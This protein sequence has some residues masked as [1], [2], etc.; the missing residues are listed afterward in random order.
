M[1]VKASAADLALVEAAHCIIAQR[2]KPGWHGVGAALRTRTGRIFTG[3]HLEAHVGRIAI[4]AEAVALGRA[5]T[6]A[7]D[8]DIDTIVAVFHSGKDASDPIIKVAAPCGMCREMISDY[9]PGA[10]VILP[11]KTGGLVRKPV[12]RLLPDKYVRP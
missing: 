1:T 11:R 8:T 6:E 5:A 4:C 9:S 7:G 12:F 2:Y 10:M 3:V